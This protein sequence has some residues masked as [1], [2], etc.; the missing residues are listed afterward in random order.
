MAGKQTRKDKYRQEIKKMKEKKLG[1]KC[2]GK[3]AMYITCCIR[4][5][6]GTVCVPHTLFHVQWVDFGGRAIYFVRSDFDDCW[7][8]DSIG[9]LE[10]H[11]DSAS[12]DEGCWG[13]LRRRE[14]SWCVLATS[15]APGG[16]AGLGDPAVQEG[17][18]ECLGITPTLL[19]RPVT[20]VEDI[21]W[22]VR[23]RTFKQQ[24]IWCQSFWC[25]Y[26]VTDMSRVGR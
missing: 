11:P 20:V 8:F 24:M 26:I 21:W 17:C 18:R 2:L 19:R 22:Y 15:S 13:S 9:C 12:I 16:R 7:R 5:I 14:G 23:V 10:D 6:A 3:N 25:T 4:N 1:T